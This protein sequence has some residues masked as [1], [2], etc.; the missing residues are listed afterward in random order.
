MLSLL[1]LVRSCLLNGFNYLWLKLTSRMM[2]MVG[3]SRAA[4]VPAEDYAF[5]PEL[6]QN[7]SIRGLSV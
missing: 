3:A 2:M 5:I 6:E 4:V 1:Y 7:R